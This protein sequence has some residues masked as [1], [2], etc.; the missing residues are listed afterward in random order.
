M[1][2]QQE[3]ITTGTLRVDSGLDLVHEEIEIMPDPESCPLTKIS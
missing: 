3:I 1:S 2:P